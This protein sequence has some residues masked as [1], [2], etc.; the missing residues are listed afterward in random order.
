MTRVKICGITSLGDAELAMKS[1]A[2]FL[3]FVNARNSPRFLTPERISGIVSSL[4]SKVP[5]VL[6]T[7]SQSL[8]EILD[9]F[10]RSGT[11][12]LQIH[13]PLKIVEYVK[14]K[15]EAKIIA[16]ISIPS[17]LEKATDG[18][19][20]R[21]EVVSEIC[22]FILFDTEVGGR[23]GGTGRTFHWS[24]AKELRSY[25][26]KPVFLAGGLKPENV[27]IPL[28]EVNPYAVDVSSG[29][30]SSPGKKDPQKVRDFINA[31]KG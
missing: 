24:V 27:A 17:T 4:K 10:V 7:H 12:I 25:C 20:K 21:V 30:E 23:I 14:M 5:T 8:E 1:G 18:L 9:S 16:N 15:D 11:D 26:R 28:R 13:A 29:V 2:D 22:D 6:V 19:V 31:V 3:G